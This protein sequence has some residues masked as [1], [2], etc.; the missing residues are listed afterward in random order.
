MVQLSEGVE[1]S[2]ASNSGMVKCV[3][4]C[5]IVECCR[6]VEWF[7]CRMVSN[8]RMLLISEMIQLSN[9]FEWSNSGSLTVRW[10]FLMPRKSNQIN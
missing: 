10:R 7:N 6:I 1:W 8:G 5:G 9:G 2:N 3:E 4:W